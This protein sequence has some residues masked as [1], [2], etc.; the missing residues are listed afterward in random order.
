MNTILLKE[1]SPERKAQK[2]DRLFRTCQEAFGQSLRALE[3]GHAKTALGTLERLV[4]IQEDISIL[5]L[6]KERSLSVQGK[7]ENK[8]AELKKYTEGFRVAVE[9]NSIIEARNF[10]RWGVEL[11]SEL[12]EL[13]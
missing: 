5:M 8:L 12:A 9:I 7:I 1:M 10:S 3:S 2:L 4:S 6:E 13:D 11:I